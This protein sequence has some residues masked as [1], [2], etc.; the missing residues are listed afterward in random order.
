MP[1][2]EDIAAQQQLLAIY[3]RNL[4]LYLQQQA[5]AGPLAVSPGVMNGIDDARQHIHRI[6]QQLQ[7]WGVDVEN[8]PDDEV[9][10]RPR[11]TRVSTSHP[12]SSRMLP[13]G[14]GI[15]VLVLSVVIIGG[16]TV[17]PWLQ[18]RPQGTTGTDA[19]GH[20]AGGTSNVPPA[21]EASRTTTT[22]PVST[23]RA[24]ITD[25]DGNQ[26]E[27]PAD[28]L[29]R[30]SSANT[31][32]YLDNRQ[33]VA[34]AN[35]KRIDVVRSSSGSTVFSITLLDNT[36]IEGT[37]PR[38]AFFGETAV[39]RFQLWDEDIQSIVIE[40]GN[41]ST[42]TETPRATTYKPLWQS[43]A[44]MTSRDGNETEVP[45]D[46]LRRCISGNTTI[47]LDN[48]QSISLDRVKRIDVVRSSGGST[49]FSIILLDNTVLEGAEPRCS[50]FGETD[51]GRF[52]LWDEDIQSIEI[53]RE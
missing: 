49:V 1:S 48:G 12:P 42:V 31:T 14:W 43:R 18:S 38:C 3:R 51:G 40:P 28:T 52:Q 2:A 35:V 41:F 27:V 44:I 53:V 30:C 39:G 5:A 46:T 7:A 19:S 36:V 9:P 45:A 34:L 24:V 17:V 26:T 20:I 23:Q 11:T 8:H 6:K 25:R 32:I 50:F 4:A 33:N 15:L 16:R 37:E 29:R 47:R 10:A 22:S 13:W 21:I